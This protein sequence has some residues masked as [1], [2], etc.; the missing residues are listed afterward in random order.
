MGGQ[1]ARAM[2]SNS[3]NLRLESALTVGHRS[4]IGVCSLQRAGKLTARV[5]EVGSGV[6][7]ERFSCEVGSCGALG[8]SFE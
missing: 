1:L 8:V 7:V 4:V 6:H 5:L 2:D 3:A